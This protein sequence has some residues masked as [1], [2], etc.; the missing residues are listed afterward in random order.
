MARVV[1]EAFEEQTGKKVVTSLN[2]WSDN[3]DNSRKKTDAD[4]KSQ[5]KIFDEMKKVVTEMKKKQEEYLER[6]EKAI[7]E[8]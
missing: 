3:L 4:Y 8:R 1:K 7:D 5:L 6:L 2:K